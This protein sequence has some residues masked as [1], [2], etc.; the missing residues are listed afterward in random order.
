MQG[1]EIMVLHLKAKP[2]NK[3]NQVSVA[4]DGTIVI[5]I[6]APAHDGK[7]NQELIKFLSEKLN[8]PKS[9][10]QLVS[11]FATPFKKFEIEA[12][13]MQVKQKLTGS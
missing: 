5:K 12:D 8:L 9:K 11:G 4:A 1:Y 2:G 13:E 6:K 3:V 7:A 10:I